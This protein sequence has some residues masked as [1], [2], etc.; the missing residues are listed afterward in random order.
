MLLALSACGT[1]APPETDTV[2]AQPATALPEPAPQT[3]R[4]PEPT[5]EI[6]VNAPLPAEVLGWTSERVAST[7]GPASLV[8]RD[9]NAEIWQYRTDDC[10][11]FVFLYDV[12][13]GNAVRHIDVNKGGDTTTCMENVVRTYILRETS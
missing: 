8:R 1:A 7:L 2:A 10:V 9:L 3:A 11:L 5:P 12:A 6:T 13:G 4:L